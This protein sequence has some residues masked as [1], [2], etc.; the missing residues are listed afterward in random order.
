MK[1]LARAWRKFLF[2]ITADP[3]KVAELWR[4]SG[5]PVGEGTHIL[6][7]VS[8]GRGGKDPISIG[9]NCV[10]TGCTILGHDASTNRALGLLPGES[11]PI[12]PVVIEDDCF[13]GSGAIILMGVRVGRGSIVGAGAVVTKDVP[14]GSVVGGNPAKVICTVAELVE[15]RKQL[16]REHP[17][18]FP[19]RPRALDA[20]THPPAKANG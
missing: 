8:L 19:V 18:Y 7:D 12:M 4:R 15:K 17:E 14:P 3:L 10:L 20:P 11:S 13:I 16:A 5:V 9:R 2:L 1:M 6:R